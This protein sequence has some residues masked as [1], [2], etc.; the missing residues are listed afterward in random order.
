VILARLAEM[1]AAQE[2]FR[3]EVRE[4]LDALDARVRRAED[5]ADCASASVEDSERKVGGWI[6]GVLAAID[7]LADE[8]LGDAPEDGDPHLTPIE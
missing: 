4:R 6:G 7:D 1:A 5:S 3:A 2:A 8:L